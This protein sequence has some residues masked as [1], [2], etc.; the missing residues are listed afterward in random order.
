MIKDK[1]FGRIFTQTRKSTPNMPDATG[2]FGFPAD[3][4]EAMTKAPKDEYGN[5][6]MEF[7]AWNKTGPKAGVYLSG[8]MQLKRQQAG[9]GSGYSG[10][11]RTQEQSDQDM[12]E[13][14]PF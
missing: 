2:Q 7:A 6:V 8:N 3:L 11:G 14:L 13:D 5:V 12:D 9:A 4:I 1:A 10:G